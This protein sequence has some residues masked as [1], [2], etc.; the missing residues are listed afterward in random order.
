MRL[1]RKRGRKMKQMFGG[2]DTERALKVFEQQ[3]R[4]RRAEGYKKKRN[5]FERAWIWITRLGKAKKSEYL[6]P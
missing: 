5:C 6:K 4:A 2:N 3:M 1:T